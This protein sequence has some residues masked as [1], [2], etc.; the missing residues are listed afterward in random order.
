MPIRMHR[1]GVSLACLARSSRRARRAITAALL[2]AF[3]ASATITAVATTAAAAP[4]RPGPGPAV[5]GT[6]QVVTTDYAF[7]VRPG[8]GRLHAGLVRLRLAN[9]G[10]MDHEAQL[11]RLHAGVSVAEFRHVLK[12][13][14]E[15]AAL[16]LVDFTGG[17]APVAPH[18]TQ[19]TYQKLIPGN[20]L[21]LCLVIGP[22]GIPHL[23]K[24]MYHPLTVTG[25]AGPVRP[26]SRVQGTITAHDM[27]YTLPAVIH[28]HGLYRFRDTDRADV[29]E[30]A[31]VR[32][33]AK[34]TRA[35]VIAWFRRPA[36]PPPFTSA[37]GFGAIPPGANGWFLL[38]LTPG[39]YAALCYVPDDKAPHLPHAAMGMVDTFTIH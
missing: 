30:L 37:G 2:A 9:D 25:R 34:A 21:L 5:A 17:A 29:H 39:H 36:G 11:T 35:D 10:R 14:G 15:G 32:L 16:A 3:T 27:T 22:D 8:A 20:Y 6:L 31:I 1:C 26:P 18:G 19:T 33:H 38:N 23:M 7:H 12:T 28:G 4:A 13:A 24:G